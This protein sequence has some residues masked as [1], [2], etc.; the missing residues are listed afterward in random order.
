MYY[1]ASS[2]CLSKFIKLKENN[3]LMLIFYA[4][5]EPLKIN[6]RKKFM[7]EIC[8]FENAH[9]VDTKLYQLGLSSDELTEIALIAAAAKNEAVPIE[10]INAPGIFSYI[11]GTGAIRSTLIQK[12]WVLSRENNI[13]A[14]L[15]QSLNVKIVFQN[16]DQACGEA[17]PQPISKKGPA[18][19][20]LVESNSLY[21]F[22]EME[23]EF[24][25]A[26]N[27]TT[28]FFCVSIVGDKIRAE[29]SCP[30]SL[31]RNQFSF[32]QR[33]FIITDDMELN[34]LD[35]ND[36]CIIDDFDITVTKK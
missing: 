35:N 19:K 24:Q 30:Y 10:P 15:N 16:V 17:F 21:L 5:I 31:D 9:D 32:H 12:G 13:E 3:V 23:K 11:A 8:I 34:T 7:P 6:I 25:A 14:T 29:L 2:L 22:P 26:K 28:W 20:K 33:I 1:W 36:D 18:T 4:T 27:T